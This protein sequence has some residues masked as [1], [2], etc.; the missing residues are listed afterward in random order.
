MTHTV[1]GDSV[2]L[3]K[4]ETECMQNAQMQKMACL[5][6]SSANKL[7]RKFNKRVTQFKV[8]WSSIKGED[9]FVYSGFPY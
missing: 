9:I 4:A 7:D 1:V 5:R 2:I 6:V 3:H 8:V